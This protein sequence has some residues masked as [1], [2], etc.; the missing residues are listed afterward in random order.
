MTFTL[1]VS[2]I[3][4]ECAS[5]KSFELVDP[6][7]GELPAFTA[8]AHLTIAVELRD[9]RVGW[10]S[11]SIAS[12]PA[13]RSSYLIA[14]LLEKHSS[15]GSE[16]MHRG[17]RKGDILRVRGPHNQFSL[18]DGASQHLLIAGG[19][20]ITP[21]LSMV[22]TLCRRSSAFELHYSARTHDAM[23]FR[24]IVTAIC[25]SKAKLYVDNGD[26]TNGMDLKG[27]LRS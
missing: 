21:I 2:R 4:D 10:R 11:Y 3:A 26:S 8:G 15:G 5:I 25:G 14:V 23:A 20:G 1:K 7:G 17:V 16:F 24:D 9:G 27:L 19:I 6:M 18:A 13:D 12:D 22:R